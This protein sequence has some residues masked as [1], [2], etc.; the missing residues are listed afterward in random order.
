MILECQKIM[1][2]TFYVRRPVGRPR[3]RWEDIRKDSSLLLNIRVWGS[4]AETGISGD[5]LWRRPGCRAAG[6]KKRTT[7]AYESLRGDIL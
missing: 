5:E 7:E 4:L 2:E 3:L 1:N 6:E